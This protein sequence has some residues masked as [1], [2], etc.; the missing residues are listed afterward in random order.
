MSESPGNLRCLAAAVRAT[1]IADQPINP[2]HA[3]DLAAVLEEVATQLDNHEKGEIL[4]EQHI[5]NLTD[6]LAIYRPASVPAIP[7]AA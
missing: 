7:T 4:Y 3:L 6:L 2:R 5:A 1:A